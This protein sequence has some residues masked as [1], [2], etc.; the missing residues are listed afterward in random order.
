MT[1]TQAPSPPLWRFRDGALA[2]DRSRILGI[3]NVTP[4]SFSD[5]GLALSPRDALRRAET[6]VREGAD[7]L[8][9]GGESTRP[10]AEPVPLEEEL[11][12]VI[13]VVREAARLG[14]PVSVDTR[15]SAVARAALAAG[16]SVVNDVS[17][18]ADP[19]MAAAAA[20][21]KAGLVLMHMRGAPRTMQDDPRYDDVVEEV[22]EF[23]AARRALAEASG[24]ARERIVLDPGIGFGKRL[25][26]NLMLLGRLDRIAGLGSPVL[27]GASRKR[28]V[29]ALTGEERPERRA[30]GSV[31]A[32]VAA[33]MGGAALFRVHDVAATR[34]ALAVADAILDHRS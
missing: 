23:L 2:L 21:A 20:E 9:V 13:P 3:V 26:H 27:V 10:G 8:D 29:G 4:D 25:E 19:G 7:M 18:L 22:R 34:Q 11:R 14:V 15:K 28:F 1:D 33:R 5:G 24:T 16:A 17:A 32:A 12:R 30:A 6:L 31:A